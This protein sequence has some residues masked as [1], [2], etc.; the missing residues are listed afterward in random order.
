MGINVEPQSLHKYAYAHGDPTNLLD[1]SGNFTMVQ[2]LV[3]TAIL[4]ILATIFLP[5]VMK[6]KKPAVWVSMIPVVGSTWEAA[7]EFQEGNYGWAAFYDILAI[8]DVFLLKTVATAGLKLLAR[9]GATGSASMAPLLT[10]S[11]TSWT[12]RRGGVRLSQQAGYWIKEVNPAAGGFERWWG[13]KAIEAQARALEKLGPMAPEF[14]YSEGKL[15]IKD[16]GAQFSGKIVDFLKLRL[17]GS[18]RMGELFNDI[19]PHNMGTAGLIFDPALHPIH[20]MAIA[21]MAYMAGREIDLVH[22]GHRADEAYE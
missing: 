22:Q 3:A 10:T 13:E 16:A 19:V 12:V 5:A 9:L 7:D 11:V 1:P 18:W 20:T 15:V 8:S 17:R 4:V 21:V 2:L 14:F 6:V